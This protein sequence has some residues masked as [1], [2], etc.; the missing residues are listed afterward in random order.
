MVPKREPTVLSSG[1]KRDRRVQAGEVRESLREGE[2][3]RSDHNPK[4]FQVR[5]RER[6]RWERDPLVYV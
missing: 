1:P 6:L 5:S 3:E 2:E 4:G